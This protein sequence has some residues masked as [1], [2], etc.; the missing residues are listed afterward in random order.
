MKCVE[1]NKEISGPEIICPACLENKIARDKE[2]EP[3]E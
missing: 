1:C 3:S 2:P